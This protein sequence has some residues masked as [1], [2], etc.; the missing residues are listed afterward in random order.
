[1]SKCD[2]ER[3]AIVRINTRQESFPKEST[4][5]FSDH[6]FIAYF[7]FRKHSTYSRQL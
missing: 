5:I 7:S 2:H 6:N 4:Y 1:M 3:M